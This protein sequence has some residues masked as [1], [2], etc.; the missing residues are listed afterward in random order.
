MPQL[1][2]GFW[3]Y[4]IDS[5]V[6]ANVSCALPNLIS[7]NVLELKDLSHLADVSK[8]CINLEHLSL[9]AT[10]FTFAEL[11]ENFTPLPN[12]TWLRVVCHQIDELTLQLSLI[13]FK[14]VKFLDSFPS[15]GSFV[16]NSTRPLSKLT[17]C[18]LEKA[19]PDSVQLSFRKPMTCP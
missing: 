7:L 19:M 10:L 4:R 14:R 9:D 1:K 13:E 8:K 12:L 11:E 16:V 6:I 17:K 5:H 2:L 18:C 15:L 3:D